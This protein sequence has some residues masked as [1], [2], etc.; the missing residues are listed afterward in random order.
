M[1]VGHASGV[2]AAL[3]S[4]QQVAVQ[5][6]DMT[7]LQ[8]GLRTQRKVLS[9]EDN[10]NGIFG[11]NNTVVDDDM[12]RFVERTGTWRSSESPLMDR[13][14]ITFLASPK[15]EPT[16]ICKMGKEAYPRSF[17]WSLQVVKAQ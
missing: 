13:H 5:R 11:Q 2:A 15:T 1:T 6:V 12:N 14:A 3:A 16:V 9:F 17:R 7:V 4:K 8:K 10:P